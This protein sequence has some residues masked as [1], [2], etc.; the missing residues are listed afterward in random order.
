MPRK[1]E[2]KTDSGSWDEEK[3]ALAIEA[4]RSKSI[5]SLK[6]VTAFSVPKTTLRQMGTKIRANVPS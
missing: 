5:D 3:M 2:R 6:S 4:V 1:Y